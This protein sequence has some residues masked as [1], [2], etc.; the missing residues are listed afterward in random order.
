MLK[1]KDTI[2]KYFPKAQLQGFTVV[3]RYAPELVK[4]Y[5]GIRVR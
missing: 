2:Q 4:K 1:V 5:L 3:N